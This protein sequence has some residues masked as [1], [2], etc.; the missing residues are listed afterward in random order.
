ME[1]KHTEI[2]GPLIDFIF[3]V[4]NNL[5]FGF[6]EQVDSN[7]MVVA[8]KRFGLDIRRRYPIKI[9]FEEIIVGRYEADLLVNKT[10]IVELK[11]VSA[12]HPEY[13]AQLLNY[14]KATEFEVGFLRNFGPK[15]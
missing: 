15:P 12:L 8:E 11:T 7:S 13:E 5:G 9:A 2:T 6:L 14:L 4:Y 1:L 3:Y 10:I